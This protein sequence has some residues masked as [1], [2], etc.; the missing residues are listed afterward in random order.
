MTR[1]IAGTLRGRTEQS[2]TKWLGSLKRR[3]ESAFI[4]RACTH[5]YAEVKREG[6]EGGREGR[7]GGDHHLLLGMRVS[8]GKIGDYVRLW[9]HLNARHC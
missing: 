7:R 5:I 1:T 6:G 3:I 2:R 4:R 8:R 9:L